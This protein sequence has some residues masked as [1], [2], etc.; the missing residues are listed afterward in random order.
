MASFHPRVVAVSVV[1][2]GAR[3]G[4]ETIVRGYT[5]GRQGDVKTGAG[6][7]W[8]QL[9]M[10]PFLGYHVW[11]A[12]PVATVGTPASLTLSVLLRAAHLRAVLG[13]AWF[14]GVLNHR[15]LL[16]LQLLL[17]LLHPQPALL[18]RQCLRG[19]GGG[20]G[21]G[22][23]LR[24]RRD[25]L[26]PVAADGQRWRLRCMAMHGVM[27]KWLV[28]KAWAGLGMGQLQQGAMRGLVH[29]GLGQD[30]RWVVVKVHVVRS[31]RGCVGAQRRR[32]WTWG[33]AGG[34]TLGRGGGGGGRGW[35]PGRGTQLSVFMTVV[36]GSVHVLLIHRVTLS[37][38]AHRPSSRVC[39]RACPAATIAVQGLG[40]G[41]V[42]R[43]VR[44][45]RHR[46]WLLVA[47]QRDPFSGQCAGAWR[48]TAS[49]QFLHQ[50]IL[51][52]CCTLRQPP[53]AGRAAS[54]S[55]HATTAWWGHQGRAQIQWAGRIGQEVE[56]V[57][58][59]CAGGLLHQLVLP[60]WVQQAGLG[61]R[62]FTGV[63]GTL[64]Q[65]WVLLL[66]VAGVAVPGGWV[67][68]LEQKE[69]PSQHT[70]PPALPAQ[71]GRRQGWKRRGAG[72]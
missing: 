53:W 7:Q 21:V 58:V 64:T 52:W 25:Q 39:C 24:Q 34:N 18:G 31:E 5:A 22:D 48:R 16:L 41:L 60:H 67:P 45:Q 70:P 66:P 4:E 63:G 32:H 65:G 17:S 27:V 57:L 29:H 28:R 56:E 46:S 61:G 44:Q 13:H 68:S 59:W 38:L 33:C 69:P 12:R 19:I 43:G 30:C 36:A 14:R 51:P 72:H 15:H 50:G 47:G 71:S 42:L 55:A 49:D 6:L 40:L 62:G 20:K 23:G 8:L 11:R 9:L 1:H 54:T 35:R 10:L 37:L 3:A 26:A 2:E